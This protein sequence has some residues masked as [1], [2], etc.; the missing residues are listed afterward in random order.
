M[1]PIVSQQ[2]GIGRYFD[3][4]EQMPDFAAYCPLSGLPRLFKT[5][6]DTIPGPIPYVHADPA[7]VEHWRSRLDALTPHGYR[8]IGLVWAGRPTHGND[9]NRSMTLKD[10]APLTEIDRTAFIS[11]QMGSAQAQLGNYYGRAPLINLGAEI[12]D[13]KDT[14][15]IL[16]NLDRLVSVD[17]GVVHLAGAMGRPVSVLLPFAPDWRWLMDRSDSPWYP[18]VTLFRQTAPS[19][20]SDV[21]AAVAT[22]LDR[23]R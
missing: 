17:T 15:A 16:A 10:L 19:R 1:F 20:W 4:W 7:L 5:E 21:V 9:F 13:F 23:K 11:L 12:K 14:M 18:S 8:R 6:L 3:R 22:S 2:P